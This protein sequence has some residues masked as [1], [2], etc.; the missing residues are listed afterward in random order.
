M[1]FSNARMVSASGFETAPSLFRN[2]STDMIGFRDFSQALNTGL[3]ASDAISKIVLRL[4]LG[5]AL[6]IFVCRFH[7][8]IVSLAP[9]HYTHMGV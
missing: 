9:N 4:Q 5:D 8:L 7:C 2:F 1:I 6:F 3:Y